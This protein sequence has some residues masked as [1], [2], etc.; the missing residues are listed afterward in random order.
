MVTGLRYHD[1][2][3]TYETLWVVSK[4]RKDFERS[5][6]SCRLNFQEVHVKLAYWT[7]S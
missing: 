3:C 7:Q 4:E 2:Q 1:I 6:T 5:V